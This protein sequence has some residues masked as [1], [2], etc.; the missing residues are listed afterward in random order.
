M[1]VDD[2]DPVAAEEAERLLAWD[3]EP[4]SIKYWNAEAGKFDYPAGW[5]ASRQKKP[6][7]ETWLGQ[8]LKD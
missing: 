8:M 2:D 1:T 7:S 6:V 4:G 3:D 5:P